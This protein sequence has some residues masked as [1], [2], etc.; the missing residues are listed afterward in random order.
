MPDGVIIR[1]KGKFGPIG[2]IIAQQSGLRYD[3]R[4]GRYK[5]FPHARKFADLT[6]H[7]IERWMVV[8]LSAEQLAGFRAQLKHYK[9]EHRAAVAAHK[10]PEIRVNIYWPRGLPE[11]LMHD[12]PLEFHPTFASSDNAITR[13]FERVLGPFIVSGRYKPTQWGA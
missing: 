7:D 12:F 4:E 6:F 11:A 10:Q 1:E 9:D 8:H 5:H 2:H 3:S 13:N